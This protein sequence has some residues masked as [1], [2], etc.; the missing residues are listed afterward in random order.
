MLQ[1]AIFITHCCGLETVMHFGLVKPIIDVIGNK[2]DVYRICHNVG[3]DK[4][5]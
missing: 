2:K 3:A 1:K 5:Q 4:A